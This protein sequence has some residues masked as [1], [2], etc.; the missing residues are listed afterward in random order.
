MA[1]KNTLRPYKFM[2]DIGQWFGVSRTPYRQI[3]EV[4]YV[5]GELPRRLKLCTWNVADDAPHPNPRT[6]LAR[7]LAHL[8]STIDATEPCVIALQD[9]HVSAFGTLLASRWVRAYFLVV[10]AR[11]TEWPAGSDVGP[12]TL[13]SARIPLASAQ[14]LVFG[15]SAERRCALLVDILI[16]GGRAGAQTLRIANARLEGRVEGFAARK[17]QMGILAAEVR[18][19]GAWAVGGIICG[20]M[21]PFAHADGGLARENGLIDAWEKDW[22][23][24]RGCEADG[25]GYTWNGDET[26]YPGRV[27][28]VLF[29]DSNVYAVR[30]VRRIGV[31]LDENGH[32]GLEVRVRVRDWDRE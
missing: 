4:P 5:W 7:V 6:R 1:T 9:V 30:K 19:T 20:S 17:A 22:D 3:P 13:M 28:K 25:E 15:R 26:M 8:A 29:T 16:E 31:G 27:D 18:G 11:P 32:C 10:P 23:V 24:G 14:M 12:V 21:N 2:P